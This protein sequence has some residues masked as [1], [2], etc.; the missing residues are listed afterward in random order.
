MKK[1]ISLGC[2][3][4]CLS[5]LPVKAQFLSGIIINRFDKNANHHG[6]WKYIDKANKRRLLCFGYFDH[7]KQV[8]EW[9]YYHPTGE[10]RMLEKFTWVGDKRV[11]DVTYYHTNGQISNSGTA[12]VETQPGMSHYYWSGDW[13]YFDEKDGSWVKTV[14]YDNGKPTKTLYLDGSIEI[15]TTKIAPSKPIEIPWH[16]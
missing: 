5:S 1:I 16:N 15:E 12:I 13:K 2:L 3:L 10:L 6:K 9:K 14:T 8:G 4:V 7:G 11:V